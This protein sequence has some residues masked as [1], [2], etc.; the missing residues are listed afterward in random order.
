MRKV[1]SLPTLA[2]TELGVEIEDE[3]LRVD[4]ESDA[5]SQCALIFRP[6]PYLCSLASAVFCGWK[7][8]S[9][10]GFPSP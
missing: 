5:S 9:R 10:P 1:S 8:K 4:L 6:S 3:I 7:R 2:K